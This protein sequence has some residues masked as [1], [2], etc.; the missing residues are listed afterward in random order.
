MQPRSTKRRKFNRATQIPGHISSTNPYRLQNLGWSSVEAPM[1]YRDSSLSSRPRDHQSFVTPSK[2][3]TE[4]S[5]QIVPYSLSGLQQLLC[6]TQL[7]LKHTK[8]F[9]PPTELGRSAI[10]SARGLLDYELDIFGIS[11]LPVRLY[12]AISTADGMVTITICDFPFALLLLCRK[13]GNASLLLICSPLTLHRI[14]Q[15]YG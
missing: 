3:Q 6:S 14:Y 15:P 9:F 10:S 13:G 1:P 4:S 7:P 12:N 2:L 11:N 8:P 5:R